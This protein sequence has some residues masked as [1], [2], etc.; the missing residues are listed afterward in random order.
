MESRE[1][2]VQQQ[3]LSS[4]LEILQHLLNDFQPLNIKKDRS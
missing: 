2:L 1:L 3:K 4:R